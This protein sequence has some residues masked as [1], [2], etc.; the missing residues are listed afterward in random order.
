MAGLL[1]PLPLLALQGNPEPLL[2]CLEM[3]G[4][5]LILIPAAIIAHEL[6]HALAAW[7]LGMEVGLVDIGHGRVVWRLELGAVTTRLRAWPLS[8]GV[9]IGASTVR[10]LR[11]RAWLVTLMGPITNAACLVLTFLGW[12]WLAAVVSPAVLL[13]W[14]IVNSVVLCAALWPARNGGQG[15]ARASDGLALLKI[16]F[17]R[18][19]QLKIYL[20]SALMTRAMVSFEREDFEGAKAWLLKGLERIPLEVGLTAN[21]AACHCLLGQHARAIALLTPLAWGLGKHAP[22]A[23]A[24]QRAAIYNTLAFALVMT[25]CGSGG[26]KVHMDEAD[27]LSAAAFAMFPCV[28]P[29]RNTRALVL[30]VKQ[31]AADALALLDY[32]HYAS[33][34][35]RQ[36]AEREVVRALAFSALGRLSEARAALDR[37]LGLHAVSRQWL[38]SLRMA[39]EPASPALHEQAPPG[40]SGRGAG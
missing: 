39:V 8:G 33:A 27:R 10:L 29:Y 26:C 12:Q 17:L 23:A 3:A 1:W 4:L 22:A 13:L 30:C 34:T 7:L 28:L 24:R 21:L 31:R 6:G 18:P 2:P 15:Q 11:T 36:A 5:L 16:P 20:I 38:R 32:V 14:V 19:E 9:H 35:P 37:A 25:H 40:V